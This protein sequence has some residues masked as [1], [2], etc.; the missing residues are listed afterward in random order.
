MDKFSKIEF[1][2]CVNAPLTDD[3][4]NRLLTA[5]WPDHRLAKFG[6]ILGRSLAYVTT[7]DKDRLIGFVNLAWDGG[8]H[9]FLLDTLVHPEFR[10]RG[11]GTELVRRAIH[12]ASLRNIKWVHVDFEPHLRGFYADSGFRPTEAG[13]VRLDV[14]SPGLD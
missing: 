1:S 8:E 7:Y 14:D 3:E 6:S 2:Y 4:M 13:L 9:A 11:I 10:H 5:S 12:E